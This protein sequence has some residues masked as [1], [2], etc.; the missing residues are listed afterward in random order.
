MTTLLVMYKKPADVAHF[1]Q[2]GVEMLMFDT[3]AA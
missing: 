2:A 3:K 1:G